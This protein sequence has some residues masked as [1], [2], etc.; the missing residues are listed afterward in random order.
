[1]TTLGYYLGQ[2]D[3]VRNHVEIAAII[4]VVVSLIPVA[5]EFVKHRKEP[6]QDVVDQVVSDTETCV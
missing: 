5:I 2:I 3:V 4:I 6:K 1:M